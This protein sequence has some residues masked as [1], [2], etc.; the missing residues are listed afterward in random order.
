M[1]NGLKICALALLAWTMMASAQSPTP[2]EKFTG[3]AAE[4][5]AQLQKKF[6][7]APPIRHIEKTPYLGGLYE[8]LLGDQMIYTDKD[9]TYLLAGALYD[10]RNMPGAMS[11]LTE[12]RM[13]ELNRVDVSAIPLSYSFKRVKGKGERVM[14]VFSDIDCP[15]CDRLEQTLRGIDNV[16]IYTFLFPLD[17]LHPDSNRKSKTIWCA[18]DRAKAWE[19]YY[20]TKKLPDNKGDCDTPI[21]KVQQ[22]AVG[23]GIHGTPGIILADGTVLSGA[24]P[25]ESLEAEMSRAEAAA[26][27][28]SVENKADSKADSK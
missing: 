13:R 16:T 17:T 6:P 4:V 7:D 3:E 27:A 23:Y 18:K 21:A 25:K 12:Q 26:K 10:A 8:V 1:K 20:T 9:V 24:L 28:S 11:N 19:D 22:L 2:V 14:Y 15:F 5:K